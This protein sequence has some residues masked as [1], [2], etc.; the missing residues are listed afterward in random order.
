MTFTTE[1]SSP[2]TESSPEGFEQDEEDNFF[3]TRQKQGNKKRAQKAAV[4]TARL[5]LDARPFNVLGIQVPLDAADAQAAA[6]QV[7][8]FLENNIEVGADSGYLVPNTEQH[9]GC[10]QHV[11]TLDLCR[12]PQGGIA[13]NIIGVFSPRS[14]RSRSQTYRALRA[15]AQA[16]KDRDP[17]LRSPRTVCQGGVVARTHQG[18]RPMGHTSLLSCG[19]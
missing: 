1:E 10:F 15:Q 16:S 17:A 7:R 4:V 14:D 19:A 6:W 3:Q 9:I 13:R 11:A 5:A 18:I 2:L 12:I 8:D